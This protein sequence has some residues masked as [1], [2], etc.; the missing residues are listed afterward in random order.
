VG[1]P[2]R[3]PMV[4]WPKSRHDKVVSGTLGGLAERWGWNPTGLRVGYTLLT[5][6]TGIL[7]GVLVYLL[8][9]MIMD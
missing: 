3:V 9:A 8:L 4:F 6:V 2:L 1:T 7:P 5:L